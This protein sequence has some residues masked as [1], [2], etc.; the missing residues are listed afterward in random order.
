[1]VNITG[2]LLDDKQPDNYLV[3]FRHFVNL[4]TNMGNVF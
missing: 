3:S 4:N 2:C 1:M